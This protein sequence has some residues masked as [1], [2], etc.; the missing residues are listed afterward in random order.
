MALAAAVLVI[1]FGA[2]LR[3]QPVRTY[4]EGHRSYRLGVAFATQENH[5]K[6]DRC[7]TDAVRIMAPLIRDRKNHDHRDVINCI[8]VSGQ[9]L[10]RLKQF[11]AAEAL[12]RIIASEYFY[13]RYAAEAHVKLARL[14]GKDMEALWK[15]EL[16]GLPARVEGSETASRFEHS[17]RRLEKCVAAYQ[18]A[19]ETEPFS[20]WVKHAR[21]DLENLNRTLES[22][23]N[24]LGTDSGSDAIRAV[25]TIE[26]HRITIRKLMDPSK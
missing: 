12:Y 9:C 19:I 17:I 5:L 10:E 3:N 14:A 16:K 13:S 4:I 20:V 1:F 6:A 25:E 2:L 22:I 23:Q 8:L 21:K 24:A 18:K 11:E 7:L 26:S 15:N